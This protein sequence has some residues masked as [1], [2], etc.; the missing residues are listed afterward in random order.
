MSQQL[1]NNILFDALMRGVSDE[2][3]LF[4]VDTMQLVNVS[5]SV[6]QSFN[7]ALPAL[8]EKSLETL[9][10]VSKDDLNAFVGSQQVMSKMVGSNKHQDIRF[11]NLQHLRAALFEIEGVSY[12]FVIKSTAQSVLL[13][14]NKY[15][16]PSISNSAA[17]RCCKL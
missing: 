11:Y 4:E 2:A 7:L 1:E 12:L 15:E 3:F 13:I 6:C 9:I 17:L 14:T 16:T 10:D 8:Q 5:E